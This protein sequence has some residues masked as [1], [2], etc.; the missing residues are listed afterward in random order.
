MRPP[1][2]ACTTR[3]SLL[4]PALPFPRALSPAP[5]L[6]PNHITC[7]A[8]SEVNSDSRFP[9]SSQAQTR[10]ALPSAPPRLPLAQLEPTTLRDGGVGCGLPSDLLALGRG[11]REAGRTGELESPWVHADVILHLGF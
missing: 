7:T 1:R 3:T 2:P 6:W 9:E 4:A 11:G 10:K 5:F 8:I